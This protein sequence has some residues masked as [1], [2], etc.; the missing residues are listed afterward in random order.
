MTVLQLYLTIAPLGDAM[1]PACFFELRA[2][3]KV[4][5]GNILGIDGDAP[6]AEYE[7]YFDEAGQLEKPRKINEWQL[8]W[9]RDELEEQCPYYVRTCESKYT[10]FGQSRPARTAMTHPEILNISGCRRFC[11]VDLANTYTILR[12]IMDEANSLG[13][14][15][16]SCQWDQVDDE[17]GKTEMSAHLYESSGGED[18]LPQ[19]MLGNLYYCNDEGCRIDT[20]LDRAARERVGA[21]NEYL[22]KR[23]EEFERRKAELLNRYNV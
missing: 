10:I 11:K 16:S 3:T 4:M 2:K 6:Q 21:V 14:D 23:D 13:A 18:E 7:G 20:L 8:I 12:S 5:K 15:Y 9:F 1:T 22:S 17:Q 19:Y